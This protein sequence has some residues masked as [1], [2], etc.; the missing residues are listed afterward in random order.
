MFFKRFFKR[1]Q[2]TPTPRPNPVEE[3]DVATIRR[4]EDG[5]EIL[6]GLARRLEDGDARQEYVDQVRS[7]GHA[8]RELTR[9]HS[10]SSTVEEDS[11]FGAMEHANEIRWSLRP[12]K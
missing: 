12:R 3:I 10:A 7:A 9:L 1:S 11:V 2:N 5:S 8:I 6:Y 4:A